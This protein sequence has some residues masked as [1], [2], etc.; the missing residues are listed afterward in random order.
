MGA[1]YWQLNDCWPVASWASIDYFL[2]WKA[3]HYYA[4][5]FFQ[6][7]MISC[8]EEGILTQNPNA[9]AQPRDIEKSFRLSVANETQTDRKLTVKWELRDKT[10]KVLREKSIPVKVPALSSLWLD[11]VEVPELAVDDEYLSY[12]LYDGQE[13]I[14]EGT[15]IFSLPKFFHY[16]DPQLSYTVKGD[17]ITVKA[18]AYAKSVEILNRKQDLVL[19][20]NYFDMDAGEKTVK[21]Q[22]GKP[23][24]IKLRSVYNIR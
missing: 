16:V 15:V 12:H 21:I 7:L 6:P 10:A 18:K 20:D 17:A 3:L 4:K 8:H 22:S 19:S 5:R 24:G 11:K 1:I 13:L 9:N 2:R 14:S 23:D